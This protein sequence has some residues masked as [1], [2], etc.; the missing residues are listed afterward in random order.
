MTI[1]P[2]FLFLLCLT[3]FATFFTTLPLFAVHKNS[4]NSI[5]DKMSSSGRLAVR[6]RKAMEAAGIKS[7]ASVKTAVASE[8][9]DACVNTS[10]D[11]EDGF[12]EGAA[13]GQ[14][15]TSIAVDST[16]KHIVVG[17][18]DT[19]GFS[20][21]PL[22]VSGV[23]YSDDGGKTFVDGGQL[24]SP[25]DSAIGTT[26]LPQVFGDPDVK[27]LGGCNFVYS[28]IL[29]AKFADTAV[30]TMGVHRSTDCGHTWTGPFEVTAA[31]NPNG[32]LD[33]GEPVDAADKEFIDVD[34][35]TGRVLMTWSNFTATSVEISSTYS[36]DILSG[37]PPT[38]STR[39]VVSATDADGQA[40]I[41]RFAGNGSSNAY[42]AWRRFPVSLGNSVAFAKSTD[43]GKTWG[44]PI[45]VTG[46]FFT[47]DQVLGND[48]VNT[49]P[50]LAVD[51]SHG[52]HRGNIYLVYSNNNS[53]DGAD[54]YFQRSTNKGATF[55]SP[56]ILNSRPG[57]DRAQWFPWVTV[58]D[59]T[60]RVFVFYYDQG[61]ARSGDLTQ[62]SYLFS[63]SGGKFWLG[64]FP[65]T[66]A[67]FKAGW[68]NDTGQPNLGDYNQGVAMGNKLLAVWAGAFQVGF[69][70]GQPSTGMNVPDVFFRRAPGF[71]DPVDLPVS[72]GMHPVPKSFDNTFLFGKKVTVTPLLEENFDESSLTP[73]TLPPGWIA[74]HGAGANT[75]RWV[76]S[77]AFCGATS[78][79]AF[80]QELEDGPPNGSSTRWERLISPSFAVPAD[81]DLVTMDFDV[82]YDTEDDPNFNI[83]A[84]DGFFLRVT[85]LTPGNTLRS[86]LAEA[87]EKEFTTG[88]IEHYPKH[89]P[90]SGDGA[91]FQDMSAWSGDSRGPQHVH[92]EFPGMAGTTA[93][94]RFEY[95][96]D[97]IGTCVDVR[98]GH[99]CGVSIDNIKVNSLKKTH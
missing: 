91:Y 13:G 5:E 40:S 33:Q 8:G 48:R 64:P 38:W 57:R 9:R 87:F 1:R 70:D 68:G 27:Y 67:P 62:V 11:C 36:D 88:R 43:N 34:S 3:L 46:P 31:T 14:A 69:T 10:D 2:K 83:L 95:T 92:M 20:L 58:D 23:M 81:A 66:H 76:T 90:R 85:D 16:G 49:S 94:L 18:N 37:N 42:V 50:S 73:G 44:A 30:Q 51:K 60:G 96:Q 7:F 54:V 52:F 74:A 97:L 28:S 22:S 79:A 84:Y 55:S 21:N 17:F 26:K 99:S 78:N 71:S 12:T 45:D 56:I 61:V 86:V 15:E 63:D 53:E 47:M 65:L 4:R 72:A 19:R 93:Q 82:C 32:L 80:H 29:V 59:E 41:P 98:P 89:F 39:Q 24:P 77:S 75:V 35:D 6:V 25:G